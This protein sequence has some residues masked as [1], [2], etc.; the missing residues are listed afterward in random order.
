MSGRKAWYYEITSE[1]HTHTHTHGGGTSKSTQCH[2]ADKATP[3]SSSQTV[4]LGLSTHT[5]DPIEAILI[6]NTTVFLS[7]SSEA[8]ITG[9]LTLG[10]GNPNSCSHACVASALTTDLFPKPLLCC[11]IFVHYVKMHCCDWFD[12]QLNGQSLVRMG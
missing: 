6:Q 1:T 2:T 11:G 10:S 4:P 12:K 7:L 9:K 3:P 5:G 8:G